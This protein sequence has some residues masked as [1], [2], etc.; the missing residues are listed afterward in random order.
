MAILE[1][2]VFDVIA[3]S[4]Q[5]P[6]KSAAA[7]FNRQYVISFAMTDEDSRFTNPLRGRL[8]TGEKAMMSWNRSP[9][10]SPS[11]SA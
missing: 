9:F 10:P 11:E 6:G 3:G 5:L 1:L 2:E 4:G 7:A 8:E